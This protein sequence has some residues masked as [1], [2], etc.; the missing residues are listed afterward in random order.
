[1]PLS[2][3]NRPLGY[4]VESAK[5]AEGSSSQTAQE[6]GIEKEVDPGGPMCLPLP[7]LAM[8]P[9]GECDLPLSSI[10][11]AQQHHPQQPG[12]PGGLAQW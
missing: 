11:P 8:E 2:L 4:S 5:I 3:S 1:M 6:T 7:T 10:L 9:S 12:L